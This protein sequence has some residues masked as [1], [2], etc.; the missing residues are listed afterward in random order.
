MGSA[1]KVCMECGLE[2]SGTMGVSEECSHC[3]NG[4]WYGPLSREGQA[5]RLKMAPV[6]NER[7][8]KE[9][10]E[11]AAA[12]IEF[13]FVSISEDLERLGRLRASGDLSDEEFSALKARL[14]SGHGIS[15]PKGPPE[16]DPST[17]LHDSLRDAGAVDRTLSSTGLEACDD[18]GGQ[19]ADSAETCPHCGSQANYLRR[20]QP[21][22]EAAKAAEQKAAQKL[23]R[24][25]D[26]KTFGCLGVIVFTIV[27]FIVIGLSGGGSGGNSELDNCVSRMKGYSSEIATQSCKSS[28]VD[29]YGD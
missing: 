1:K 11:A 7:L 4:S 16:E 29:K 14:I 24:E 26:I 18:C 5:F 21:E 10:Q 8:A 12:S 3:G 6:H 28:L 20:T 13:Q 27:A 2:V 9:A 25:I 17:D 23:A 22:R 15:D 19:V